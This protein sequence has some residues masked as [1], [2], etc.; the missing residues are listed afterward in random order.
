MKV[1]EAF[2][3]FTRLFKYCRPSIGDAIVYDVSAGNPT[4]PNLIMKASCFD[5]EKPIGE[6][7][8]FIISKEWVIENVEKILESIDT[9][10][11]SV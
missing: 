6:V 11:V 2:P 5:G 1:R 3:G 9:N 7:F 8:E 4:D 10:K